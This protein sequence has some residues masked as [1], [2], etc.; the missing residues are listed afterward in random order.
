MRDSL[1]AFLRAVPRLRVAEM[2]QSADAA[3]R[4]TRAVQPDVLVL[5]VNLSDVG[6]L[7]LVRGLRAERPDLNLI[8]LADTL[9]QRE[10]LAAAGA[11]HALMKGCLDD[12][13]RRALFDDPPPLLPSRPAVLACAR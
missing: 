4:L 1:V 5:D 3:M 2:A 13:L 6:I 7:D 11:S 9:R 8:V 12:Q 10:Q